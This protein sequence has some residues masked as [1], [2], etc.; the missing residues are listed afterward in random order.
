MLGRI[1]NEVVFLPYTNTPP[2]QVIPAA[3]V[4]QGEISSARPLVGVVSQKSVRY[5]VGWASSEGSLSQ[6]E[7]IGFNFK[8]ETKRNHTE[9]M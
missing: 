1:V 3:R 2:F 6:V 4:K 8:A 7:A 9:G 5:I